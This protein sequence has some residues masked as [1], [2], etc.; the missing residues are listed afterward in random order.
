MLGP[1]ATRRL[2]SGSWRYEEMTWS[3]WNPR[4]VKDLSQFMID[5]DFEGSAA[6]DGDGWRDTTEVVG[7]MDF[8][9]G[10]GDIP[11]LRRLFPKGVGLYSAL[12]TMV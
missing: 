5:F 10:R 11:S 2:Y 4:Q 6:A 7:A 12:A 3:A 1:P 8:Y 9:I